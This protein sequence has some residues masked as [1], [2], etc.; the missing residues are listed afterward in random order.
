MRFVDA[1]RQARQLSSLLSGALLLFPLCFAGITALFV[2]VAIAGLL[3]LA[4]PGETTSSDVPLSEATFFLLL[5][6]AILLFW[7][8][9]SL[10]TMGIGAARRAKELKGG[11]VA[12]ARAIGAK[13]VYPSTKNPHEQMLLNLTEE[14]ALATGSS[15]P[16][17]Y[18]LPE[19]HSINAFAAGRAGD[20]TV[21]GVTN[22]ALEYLS[23]E[24]LQAVIAHE[25]GHILHGDIHL[26]LKLATVTAGI[27]VFYRTARRLFAHE[28][29]R[30][31]L[32]RE[33]RSV[34]SQHLSQEPINPEI[35]IGVPLYALGIFGH[36]CSHL[37]HA[38]VSRQ[39]EYL[40]DASAVQYTR[41]PL[42]L[43]T[44]LAKIGGSDQ[45]HLFAHRQMRDFRHFF[46]HTLESSRLEAYLTTHP[47]L[48]DRI[49]RLDPSFTGEFPSPEKVRANPPFSHTVSA[50]TTLISPST[51]T[52]TGFGEGFST[53]ELQRFFLGSYDLDSP[54]QLLGSAL[55]RAQSMLRH[56][57]DLLRE[58]VREPYGARAAVVALLIEPD[59]DH[60]LE[61]INTVI[62]A[63]DPHLE[64]RF[65]S[66]HRLVA[67]L[68][69]AYHLP[70]LHMALPALAELSPAETKHFLDLLEKLTTR[71]THNTSLEIVFHELVIRRLRT[72]IY[73]DPL[74]RRYRPVPEETLHE[75]LRI[76]AL[77]GHGEHTNTSEAAYKAGCTALDLSPR[78]YARKEGAHGVLQDFPAILRTLQV[79]P[80]PQRGRILRAAATV[81][82]F[83]REIIP[84][85]GELLRALA[86]VL[87]I[88]GTPP[89]CEHHW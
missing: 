18:L 31:E 4:A 87:G 64:R 45:E 8:G 16:L 39:R 44:A 20:D 73:T 68:P 89:L 63:G 53:E 81:I 77:V 80:P 86:E 78:P 11:G 40:A 38:A 58:A 57:P 51:G 6:P 19:N 9:V 34:L 49:R 66:L 2:A 88:V 61:Q 79:A 82:L 24:E 13:R 22:G 36:L 71:R 26:T 5:H 65:G 25:F 74:T 7:G 37:L 46:L 10:L 48:P 30:Q 35:L 43:A 14:M 52:S 1:Q 84:P 41:N 27:D 28:A 50:V 17:L 70:L 83:D 67:D 62:R 76:L 59:G 32:R 54:P 15:V 85:E 69:A 72:R 29:K 56:L 12:V 21:I 23:R 47:P 33:H 60:H 3:A 55:E 42:A 75:L